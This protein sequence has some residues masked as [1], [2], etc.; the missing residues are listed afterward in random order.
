MGLFSFL[1]GNR[2]RKRVDVVTDHIWMTT[3]A[4]FA[5]IARDLQKRATSEP[6]AILLVAHF[7]DVLKRLSEL[8]TQSVSVPIRAVM[9]D[10]LSTEFAEGLELDEAS[11]LEIIVGERH[12]LSDVDHDL[13]QFA[14]AFPCRCRLSHHLSLEDPVLKA[15][16]TDMV[17]RVLEALR[18]EED[19]SISS[20][21]VSRRIQQAQQKIAA[22]SRGNLPADSAEEWLEMNCPKLVSR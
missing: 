5:G 4:K 10:R 8:A 15:F 2:T 3:D 6:V 13:L 12:P 9:A 7:P 22:A 21:V 18:V 1:F 17:R 19:E 11:V 16:D 20:P 14:D